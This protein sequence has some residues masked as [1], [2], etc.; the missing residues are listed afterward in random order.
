VFVGY[1][2]V[3]AGAATASARTQ[4]TG[5][6]L[7]YR[8]MLDRDTYYR[9]DLLTGYRQL[10]LSDQLGA[11]FAATPIGLNSALAPRLIGSDNLHTRNDFYGPQLGLCASTGWERFTLEGHATT[12]LG[13]TVSDLDYSRERAIYGGSGSFTPLAPPLVGI[14]GAGT[15]P[16]APNQIPLGATTMNGTLTYFGVVAE[17]GVRL[18]W[19]ATDNVRLLSGYS[20]LY[21][22]DVRRA[23]DLFTGSS[24]LRARTV[25][26]VTHLLSAG[27]EVKY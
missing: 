27:L 26:S 4:I 14:P 13:V 25:D 17:G 15:G 7:N 8:Y 12:A 18:N 3:T 23:P 20:C 11:S 10:Y 22:N 1:P 21:W 16:F 2:G 5:G 19:S 6:D 24:V 9:I